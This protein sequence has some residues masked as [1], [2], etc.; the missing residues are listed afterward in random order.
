MEY[1]LLS[2]E[3]LQKQ[4]PKFLQLLWLGGAFRLFP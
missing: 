2:L 1:L 3:N 4:R